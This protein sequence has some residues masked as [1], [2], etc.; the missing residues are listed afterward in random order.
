LTASHISWALKPIRQSTDLRMPNRLL[1]DTH[2]DAGY[3]YFL[4]SL[5]PDS[6]KAV[7]GYM[8]PSLAGT[9]PDQRFQ[10]ERFGYFM[11]DHLDHVA[12]G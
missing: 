10:F 11:A 12:G 5:D 1:A 9:E 3:K 6:L 8:K 2:P 4:Q 7:T